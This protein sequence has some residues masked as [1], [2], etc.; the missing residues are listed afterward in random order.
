MNVYI[1]TEGVKKSRGEETLILV[2]LAELEDFAT[3]DEA[4]RR[5]WT[6]RPT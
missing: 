4:L 6:R 1:Y 2:P 5:W 3:V